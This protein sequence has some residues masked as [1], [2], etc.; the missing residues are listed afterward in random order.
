M[1]TLHRT[2]PLLPHRDRLPASHPQFDTIMAAHQDAIERGEFAYK[3]PSSGLVVMT[4][5]F[6]ID[7]GYCC[8]NGCRHCPYIGAASDE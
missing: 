2:Q 1:S 3:D 8:Q 4:A 7:R 5:T 6:H